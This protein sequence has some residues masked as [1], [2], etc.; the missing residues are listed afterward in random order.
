MGKEG[1]KAAGN[2]LAKQI[3]IKELSKFSIK[4]GLDYLFPNAI[5]STINMAGSLIKSM[6]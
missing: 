2:I 5:G 3:G 4:V 6:F 1:L